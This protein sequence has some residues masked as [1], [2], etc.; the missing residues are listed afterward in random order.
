MSSP[1]KNKQT[2]PR[3]GDH[4]YFR[5]KSNPS[6]PVFFNKTSDS[7]NASAGDEISPL[8][9]KNVS[10]LELH[11]EEQT[12]RDQVTLTVTECP[13]LQTQESSLGGKSENAT[14]LE[15]S[16][17]AMEAVGEDKKPDSDKAK[18]PEKPDKAKNA[19]VKT[20]YTE[21]DNV[22]FSVTNVLSENSV[23]PESKDLE[24][25][26]NGV[27]IS[28]ESKQIETAN[29]DSNTVADKDDCSGEGSDDEIVKEV[30]NVISHIEDMIDE[31]NKEKES[32]GNCETDVYE[33]METEVSEK[34]DVKETKEVSEVTE[35][36][37]GEQSIKILRDSLGDS[38][39]SATNP[40]MDDEVEEEADAETEARF[41]D[42]VNCMLKLPVE[43]L[44]K[45]LI[46]KCRRAILMCLQRFSTHYK[47]HYWLAYIY[48]HSPYHR[49]S[50]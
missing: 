6:T 25:A 42:Q 5:Q 26:K 34:S 28:A 20:G 37:K 35:K 1:L 3:S 36:D 22:S 48:V 13:A 24:A 40:A 23:K 50:I 9:N 41:T 16:G 21:S 2:T 39:G 17:N 44:H 43:K 29:N 11:S 7:L 8:V 19:D 31:Y 38:Q 15:E 46:E 14:K 49:V 10:T 27:D 47:S 32:K 33:P 4:T 30:R 18:I 45:D 12:S